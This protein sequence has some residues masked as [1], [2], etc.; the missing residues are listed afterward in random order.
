MD[1]NMYKE[2]AKCVQIT[3]ISYC[4][5]QHQSNFLRSLSLKMT[6][7]SEIIASTAMTKTE[8]KVTVS[9]EEVNW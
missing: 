4:Q 2:M 9:L 1:Y 8:V 7:S 3:K 5:Q 6:G